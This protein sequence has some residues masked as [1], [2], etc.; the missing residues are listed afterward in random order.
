MIKIS[1]SILFLALALVLCDRLAFGLDSGNIERVQ[2]NVRQA[3]GKVVSGDKDVIGDFVTAG[4]RELLLVEEG[5]EMSDIRLQIV[6]FA[7]QSEQPSEYSFVYVKAVKTAIVPILRQVSG[8]PSSERKTT[9]ELNLMILLGHLKSCELSECG[10]PMLSHDNA[11]VKYWAVKVVADKSIARQLN[12]DI[13]GDAEL[14]GQIVSGLMRLMAEET[15]AVVLDTITGFAAI[16]KDSGGKDLLKR[17]CM[18]RTKAYEN[19]SVTYAMMDAALLNAVAGQI[20]V[21]DDKQGDRVELLRMFA[22]L[23]S[24]VMQRYLLGAEVLDNIS[25]RNLAGVM[26]DVEEKGLTK[27]MGSRQTEIKQALTRRDLR[28][29]SRA[30]G[31]ILGTKKRGGLLAYKIKFDYGNGRIYPKTLKAPRGISN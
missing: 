26:L 23:Y 24:Y 2:E 22:Q 20:D 17:V 1:K 29:L 10:L 15:P 4:L 8:M 28:A 6:R 9:I 30:H 7:D 25:K 3:G 12:S 18:L 5:S 13:T 27:M 21:S 31:A 14:Q 16:L 11:A 19:W